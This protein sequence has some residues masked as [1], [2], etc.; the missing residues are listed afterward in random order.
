MMIKLALCIEYKMA[1]RILI[2]AND[3]RCEAFAEHWDSPSERF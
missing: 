1:V 3:R 2:R